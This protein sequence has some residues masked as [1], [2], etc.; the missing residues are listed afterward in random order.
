MVQCCSY[1]GSTAGKPGLWTKGH[2]RIP[3]IYS[4]ES[5]WDILFIERYLQS[6]MSVFLEMYDHQ[7]SKISF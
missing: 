3:V 2:A 7:F 6:C 5:H 4:K 1:P